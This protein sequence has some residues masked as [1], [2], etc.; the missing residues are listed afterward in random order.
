MSDVPWVCF[1]RRLDSTGC[2]IDGPL[3]KEPIRT[4]AVGF[5]DPEANEPLLRP[6]SLLDTSEPSTARSP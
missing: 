3:V 6:D 5:D 4:F 2:R 1:C